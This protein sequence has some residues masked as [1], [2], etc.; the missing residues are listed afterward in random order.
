[1]KNFLSVLLWAPAILVRL[2]LIALGI[3]IVGFALTGN[4][5]D[6]TPRLWRF[7]GSA[8][9]ANSSRMAPGIAYALPLVLGALAYLSYANLHP[10]LT[11]YFIFS[12]LATVIAVTDEHR[13]DLYWEMAIRNPT[14]GLAKLFEQPILEPR[15]NPDTLVRTGV[16][17]SASRFLRDG[18]FSEYWYLRKVGKK[19]F[20]FR[21]GWK[22]A[23]GTPGF[24]PTISIRLGG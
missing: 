8:E 12:A 19:Y 7:W 21:I 24:T 10:L 1:M 16:Q 20:E 5:A 17:K 11:I 3:P 13:L 4:G 18:L 9:E 14:A 22:F 15:P 2:F 23:D 6:R